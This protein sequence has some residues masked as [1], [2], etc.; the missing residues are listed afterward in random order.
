[1]RVQMDDSPS[2]YSS[3]VVPSSHLHHF[4]TSCVGVRVAV[5]VAIRW[6]GPRGV[7]GGGDDNREAA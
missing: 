6:R 4:I 1:M 7:V 3:F 5:V 2:F